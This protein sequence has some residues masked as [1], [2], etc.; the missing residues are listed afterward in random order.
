VGII[1][2]RIYKVRGSSALW[3]HDGNE[4][5]RPWGFYVHGCIDGHSRLIIYPIC[6]SNKW[7]A[8]VAQLFREAVREFGWPS[9]MR[10]DFGTENNEVEHLIIAHWGA[11]HRA[12]LRGRC[13]WFICH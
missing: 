10:G 11:A 3:N 5:L 13:A 7:Q 12:Y 4:K 8:T 6:S 2:C 9:R 1:K